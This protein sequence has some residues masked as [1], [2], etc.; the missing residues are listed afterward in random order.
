MLGSALNQD[1]MQYAF[2][3]LS[4]KDNK[5]T[6]PAFCTALP[7]PTVQHPELLVPLPEEEEGS[8]LSCEQLAMLNAQSLMV[9]QRVAAEAADYLLRLTL[10]R[11]LRR[12]ATY[13][14]L[15]GGSARSKYTVPQAI[16]QFFFS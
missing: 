2:P 1:Q 6:N 12:F 16:Q 8:T 5:P 15:A 11:D 9:N 13:F 4:G 7:A 3:L 10:V 14:D